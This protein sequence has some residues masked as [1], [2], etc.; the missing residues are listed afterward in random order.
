M[1]GEINDEK[2]IFN[3][4]EVIFEQGETILQAPSACTGIYPIAV[5]LSGPCTKARHLP[6]VSGGNYPCQRENRL[7]PRVT[8]YGEGLQV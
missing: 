8:P 5:C 1:R 7:Q 2:H 3:G 6:R 4:I